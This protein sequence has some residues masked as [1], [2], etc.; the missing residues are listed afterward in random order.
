MLE[1]A[2]YSVILTDGPTTLGFHPGELALFTE[3]PGTF[4]QSEGGF[5]SRA[6]YALGLVPVTRRKTL[7]K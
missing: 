7:L 2:G 3:K 1:I 5:S 4:P 6:R